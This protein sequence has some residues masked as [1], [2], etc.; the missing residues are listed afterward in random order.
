VTKAPKKDSPTDSAPTSKRKR[1]VVLVVLGTLLAGAGYWFVL[2]PPADEAPVPGEVVS[3]EPIQVNLAGGHYLKVGIALQMTAETTEEVEGSRALDAVITAFSG[4]SL[5]ALSQA[6][7]REQIK[8]RLAADVKD[9]YDGDV[10]DV[11]FTDFV[12][13]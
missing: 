3:L 10:M 9:L 8:K 2:R 11:Y 7:K 12:T 6:E 4:R 5:E 1:L 13:Q